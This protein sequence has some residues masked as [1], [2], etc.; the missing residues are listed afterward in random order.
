MLTEH[1]AICK[2]TVAQ[3]AGYNATLIKPSAVTSY[4]LA[5]SDYVGCL[6][7]NAVRISVAPMCEHVSTPLGGGS[8]GTDFMHLMDVNV[9]NA[10]PG[11]S[12]PGEFVFSSCGNTKT[13]TIRSNGWIQ[14]QETQMGCPSTQDLQVACLSDFDY[15]RTTT[16]GPAAKFLFGGE[17]KLT[18][19]FLKEKYYM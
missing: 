15:V 6:P 7:K 18:L 13:L 11:I 9:G 17:N 10:R 8:D 16:V 1:I 5:H 12:P 19:S 2:T 14:M 3:G 4:T